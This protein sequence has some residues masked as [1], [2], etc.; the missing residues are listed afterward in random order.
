MW[1][2]LLQGTRKLGWTLRFFLQTA[3]RAAASRTLPLYL[4]VGIAAVVLFGGHGMDAATLTRQ[5]SQQT[6]FRVALLASWTL[7][8]LPAARAWLGA[9][10]TVLIRALPLSRVVVVVVLAS[11]LLVIQLPWLVL[12]L[13]GAGAWAGLW[14]ACGAAALA[15]LSVAGVRGWVDTVLLALAVV[16][17][18]ASP[19]R[20]SALVAAA[21]AAHWVYRAWSRA[22][23]RSLAGRGWVWSRGP[24]L[25]EITALWVVL[26][27]GHSAVLFRAA[28]LALAAAWLSIVGIAHGA[29]DELGATSLCL[30]FWVPAATF[31]AAALAGPALRAERSLVWIARISGAPP[32][33]YLAPALLV[34]LWAV[35][36]AAAFALIVASGA[37]LGSLRGLLLGVACATAGAATALVASALSRRALHGDG[38]DAGRVLLHN[39]GSLSAWVVAIATLGVRAVPVMA[40]VSAFALAWERAAWRRG[41]PEHGV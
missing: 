24:L 38:R 4:A 18:S 25:A 41:A 14:A 5:A 19:S 27:R 2:R 13:R 20:E 21:T 33:V 9:P 31:G 35:V 15:A 34:A 30:L 17:A 23:E 12:W 22:P 11:G 40:L 37:G 32:R 10:E 16:A 39:L 1:R 3:G 6:G 8:A 26:F 28:L 7:A 36:M 29:A